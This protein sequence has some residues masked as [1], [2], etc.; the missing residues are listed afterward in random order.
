VAVTTGSWVPVT[1]GSWVA[2]KTGA[3]E[4]AWQGHGSLS[5][6]GHGRLFG[7]VM[8]VCLAGS[9]EPV[10]TRAVAGGCLSL[11]VR[12]AG[13][14]CLLL[15]AHEVCGTELEGATSCRQGTT[16]IPLFGTPGVDAEASGG[17]GFSHKCVDRL[18]S[19]RLVLDTLLHAS[20]CFSYTHLCRAPTREHLAYDTR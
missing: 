15:H 2:A 18:S 11:D 5:R 13:A 6:Q 8:G 9:L 20:R 16:L 17:H 3:W 1:T 14:H 19:A 7:R 4:P 10:M 12:A